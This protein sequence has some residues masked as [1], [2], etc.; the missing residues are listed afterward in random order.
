MRQSGISQITFLSVSF[1]FEGRDLKAIN[2]GPH[3]KSLFKQTD[4]AWMEVGQPEKMSKARRSSCW[5][6]DQQQKKK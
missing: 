4:S 6:W 3:Q 5:Y 1:P 2:E